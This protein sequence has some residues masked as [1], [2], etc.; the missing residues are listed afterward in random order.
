MVDSSRLFVPKQARAHLIN[1]LHQTHMSKE[2]MWSTARRDWFWIG[3]KEELKK[4]AD[5]CAKCQ[6]NAISKVKT[7]PV[8]PDDVA[9]MAVMER[10]AVDVFHH[11]NNK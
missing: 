2:T 3:L 10:V 4:M 5:N 7:V 9:E 8:I 11:G 1:T 6:E